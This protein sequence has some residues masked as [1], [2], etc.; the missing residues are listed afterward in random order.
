MAAR[1]NHLGLIDRLDAGDS[2][3]LVRWNGR[4]REPGNGKR[5]DNQDDCDHDQKFDQGKSALSITSAAHV[6]PL[7]S[8]QPRSATPALAAGPGIWT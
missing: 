2:R 4:P 3:G 5:R 6:K 8:C 1:K 7:F